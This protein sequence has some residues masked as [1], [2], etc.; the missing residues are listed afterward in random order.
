VANGL[1]RKSILVATDQSRLWLDWSPKWQFVKCHLT[2]HWKRLL[3]R[4]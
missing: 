3:M 1:G 4:N 2:M